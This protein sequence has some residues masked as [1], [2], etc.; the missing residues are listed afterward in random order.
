M[1][2][3][4]LNAAG[5]IGDTVPIG[6]VFFRNDDG[7]YKTVQLGWFTAWVVDTPGDVAPLTT[8]SITA[9]NGIDYGIYIE[10]A[11]DNGLAVGTYSYDL[12]VNEGGTPPLKY[13]PLEGTITL[14]QDVTQ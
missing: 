10:L 13:T 12:Q 11:S 8:L 7:S 14:G 6:N 2:T 3:Q 9:I 5:K 4:I 1:A